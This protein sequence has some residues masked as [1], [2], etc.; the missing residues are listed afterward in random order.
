MPSPVLSREVYFDR[1]AGLHGGYDPRGS[2]WARTWLAGTYAVARP[3]AVAGVPPDLLTFAGLAV[4]AGGVAACL[5]G[6]AWPVLA[7]A[8]VVLS[9]L[10]DSLDGAVA[11]LSDRTTRWGHVLDSVV[12]RASDLLYVVALA[13]VGA[14]GWLCAVGGALAL[15]QE[16][17]RA[18]AGVAGMSEVGVITLWERPTRIAV[19]ALFLVGA[20][21]Y[22][23][24][25]AAWA[26]AGAAAW[27]TLG[28]VGL[29]QLLVVV[30]RRLR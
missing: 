13:V 26:S 2:W 10:A 24:A 21:L 5:P 15:L 25:A 4:S 11:V 9:G 18:R 14:P 22:V 6:G 20:G 30:R 23:D 27:A 8:I 7:G 28:A 19:T 16:Y 1:W 12:D 29:G 17:A 3:L